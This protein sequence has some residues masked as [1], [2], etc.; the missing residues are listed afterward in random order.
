MYNSYKKILSTLFVEY[1]LYLFYFELNYIN[2]QLI[3]QLLIICF[4]TVIL[5]G[6]G[7]IKVIKTN[8]QGYELN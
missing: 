4:S 7:M 3:R 5:S 2:Y 6:K 1:I 8:N